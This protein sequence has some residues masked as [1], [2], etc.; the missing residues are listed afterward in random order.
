MSETMRAAVL[1][2]TGGPGTLRVERIPVPVLRSGEV[3]IRVAA[4]GLN[5]AEVLQRRGALPAPPGGVPGLECAGTVA[6]TGPEVT[7]LRPGDRVA[8]LTRSGA[9]AE[10]VAVPEGACLRLPEGLDPVVAGILPEAAATAW[11]NLVHRG[12]VRAGDRVLVHGAAG[13]VGSFVVQLARGLGA[14]VIGTARG[15]SKTR[16]CVDL[17][18]R[19]VLDYG[20][21]DIFAELRRLAPDGVDV[22]ID[23]QG[24]PTLAANL[25]ALAP[26]GRLVV[27]GT[28]GGAGA[29][30]D[31]SMLMA[32]GAEISSSSLGKLDDAYRLRLCREV[33][34]EVLP[35]IAVG[36]LRPVLDRRFPLDQIS[37][38][39]RRF[40]DP[41][42]VGKVAVVM[43]EGCG[44]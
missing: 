28:Q 20:A 42:R 15:P 37:E 2:G 11:W 21:Q 23:N 41:G 26:L 29:A 43:A 35:R 25:A 6:V 34:R 3:L 17:G 40:E 33:E 38:A 4:F 22:I 14:E 36:E 24:G 7:A 1:N 10:Y 27:V 5:N 18:C 12:R 16:L 31:L 32:R 8:A 19:H 44:D 39:H 9:Y 30:L 13:G